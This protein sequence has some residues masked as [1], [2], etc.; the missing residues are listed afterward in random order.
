MGTFSISQSTNAHRNSGLGLSSNHLISNSRIIHG[1]IRKSQPHQRKYP[2]RGIRAYNALMPTKTMA[3]NMTLTPR[4]GQKLPKSSSSSSSSFSVTCTVRFPCRFVSLYRRMPA[5]YRLLDRGSK[6][7][8]LSRG[9]NGRISQRES[10]LP[11]VPHFLFQ[12]FGVQNRPFG[13]FFPADLVVVCSV[14]TSE[15]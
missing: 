3:P 13:S 2:R 8:L 14:A 11:F 1:G 12:R 15:H 10:V 5:R 6:S 4:L 7:L 9:A